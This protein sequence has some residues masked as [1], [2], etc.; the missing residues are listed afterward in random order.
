M[1]GG[2]S[3]VLRSR[4]I[5][6]RATGKEMAWGWTGPPGLAA[7]GPRQSG[8]PGWAVTAW[9]AVA[10]R[11]MPPTCLSADTE[12]DWPELQERSRCG[13]VAERSWRCW[14]PVSGGP[15]WEK[16]ARCKSQTDAY[17]LRR[18]EESAV[19]RESLE[20]FVGLCRRSGTLRPTGA[21]HIYAV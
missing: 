18:P 13:V 1:P 12:G 3:P 16:R 15:R 14:G 4:R 9:T 19:G 20:T 2:W 6:G 5:R 8:W 7:R 21:G 10:P 11:S 17:G